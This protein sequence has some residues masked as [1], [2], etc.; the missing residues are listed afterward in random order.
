MVEYIDINNARL[1][2]RLKGPPNAPLIITLHGGRGFGDHTSDFQA[3]SPLSDQYRVLSFDFRGHGRSSRTKPYTFAQI[4]EDIEGILQAQ[5]YPVL[6]VAAVSEGFWRS[7]QA[8]KVLEQRLHK[9]PGLSVEMLRNK[10]FGRFDSDLEF[11]LVMHAAA[12]LYSE[13][14]DANI[15]LQK[16]LDTV[17]FAESIVSND[18]YAEPE[19]F[20]DYRDDLPKIT[21]KTLVIVGEKDWICPPVQSEFIASRI[22]R[23]RLEVVSNANHSVHLEQNALVIEMIRE[24]LKS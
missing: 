16:N 12:P 24:H 14:F 6:S 19:K 17:F 10:I 11:R 1:A 8:I 2:Y 20:F 3:Y 18:L 9:A 7:E 13:K 5:Q 4:V 21:A 23:A 22:P 15:A